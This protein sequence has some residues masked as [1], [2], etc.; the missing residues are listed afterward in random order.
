MKP[1]FNRVT[2]LLIVAVVLLGAWLYHS[3][4]SG[5][6]VLTADSPSREKSA[7]DLLR[8]QTAP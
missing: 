5:A 4:N 7:D 1:K 6:G 3:M 8:E 2:L